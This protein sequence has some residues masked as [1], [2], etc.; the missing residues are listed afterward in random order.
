LP[1]IRRDKLFDEEWECVVRAVPKRQAD[2]CAGRMCSRALLTELGFR[3]YPL[4]RNQDGSPRWPTGIVGSISHTQGLCTAVAARLGNIVGLGVDVEQSEALKSELT[5][6]VCTEAEKQ[7]LTRQPD[8]TRGRLAKLMFCAK[9]SAFKCQF[10]IS[11]LFIDF[12]EAQIDID[13][14]SMR[15]RIAI[16]KDM[17]GKLPANLLIRGKFLWQD[18]HVMASSILYREQFA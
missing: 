9:E 7:W 8:Y 13:L 10:P 14:Q 15:Y 18:D 1:E 3:D 4:L 17:G 2:F 16:T 6:L 11:K 12:R 5:R